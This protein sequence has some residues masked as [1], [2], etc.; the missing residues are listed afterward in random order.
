MILAAS[1][2]LVILAYGYLMYK[3]GVVSLR[4]PLTVKDR[5]LDIVKVAIPVA[6]VEEMIF[7]Y[8]I[9][10]MLLLGYFKLE[11]LYAALISSVFFSLT[12]FW[13]GMY[14]K[15][16]EYKGVDKYY[17]AFGL[18]LFAMVLSKLYLLN[19]WYGVI[20]HA[21]SIYAV[22]LHQGIYK[23]EEETNWKLFDEGHQL[24][25]CPAIWG[26]LITYLLILG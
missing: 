8:G 22:Q 13:W 15:S 19:F 17:L 26:V 3:L 14:S 4:N 24:L 18:F 2:F 20:F 16:T 5:A 10:H 11:Y 12:H 23:T 21:G 1:V 6:Y 7:R 25:R 9:F